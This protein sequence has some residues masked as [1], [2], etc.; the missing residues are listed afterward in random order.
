MVER[1]VRSN[2]S[3]NRRLL[4]KAQKDRETLV[5]LYELPGNDVTPYVTWMSRVDE[6]EAT[7]WGH[8]FETRE[9]AEQDFADRL[10]FDIP[11]KRR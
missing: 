9:E 5:V 7:F 11:Y 6:P 10:G 3:G 8:Y 4:D 2:F 1:R